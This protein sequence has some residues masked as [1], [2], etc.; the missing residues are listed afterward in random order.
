MPE[1][2]LITIN[3]NDKVGLKRTIKSVLSQNFKDFE[4]II[5]DGGSTDGSVDVIQ[6][7][8]KYI[9]YWISEKDK[10]IYNAQNKGLKIAKGDYC[11][12][13]NSG[14]YLAN[15]NVLKEIFSK[16]YDD[17]IIYGDMLIDK[18][19]GK[20]HYGSQPDS[21]NLDFML[22]TTLWH[23]VS[24]IKRSLFEKTGYYKEDLKITSD[25]DFFLNAIIVQQVKTR[26]VPVAVSVFNTSGIGSSLKYKKMHLLERKK[27]QEK[28]F[29]KKII[30]ESK[31]RMKKARGS[32]ALIYD[33]LIQYPVLKKTASFLARG[34]KKKVKK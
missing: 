5:I 13:L 3:R 21:I 12:F 4:F 31:S 25:Y 27:I 32:K 17:D 11:L 34:I 30:S 24:F 19:E 2:S 20:L 8:K 18:G 28:Y 15:E 1:L 9:S 14:D 23:P 10:G 6:N 16:N 22:H 7:Y 29:S 26:H 33:W